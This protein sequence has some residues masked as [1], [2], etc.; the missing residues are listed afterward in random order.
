MAL[1][2]DALLLCVA[3][4]LNLVVSCSFMDVYQ[5]LLAAF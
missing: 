3:K 2:G 1:A 4:L 5:F